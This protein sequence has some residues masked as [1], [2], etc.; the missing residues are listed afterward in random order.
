MAGIQASDQNGRK[1]GK[2]R[3]KKHSIRLDM[4]PMVDLAFLLLTFFVVTATFRVQKSIELAFPASGEAWP[5]KKGITFLLGKNDR[6]FYYEGEFRDTDGAQG[7]RTEL[8]ELHFADGTQG[9]HRFLLEKNM[10]LHREI[11]KLEQLHKTRQLDDDSF[12]QQVRAQKADKDAYTYFIKADAEATYKNVID[13][14]DELNINVVGK[15]LVTDMLQPELQLLKESLD[16]PS[17][18]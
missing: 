8:S 16:R 1:S 9:L 5:V 13:V 18:P 15:Y 6:L 7:K 14:V 2:A 3:Y 12:K 10:V 11:R 4:T 17:H